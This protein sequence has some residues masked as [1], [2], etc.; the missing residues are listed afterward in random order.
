MINKKERVLWILYGIV[1]IVLFLLSSTDLIIKEKKASVYPIS[2]IIEDTSDDYYVN[3][4]KGMERAAV[5]LNADI[6]FITLYEQGNR[7]QQID[8]MLREQENEEIALIM[9]PVDEALAEELQSLKRINVPLVLLNVE[10]ELIKE[11]SVASVTHDYFLMGC[12]LG[13]RIMREQTASH[14]VYILGCEGHELVNKRILLGLSSVLEPAGYE[15]KD[16]PLQQTDDLKTVLK[17]MAGPSDQGA[18][19]AALDPESLS[20]AAQLAADDQECAFWI[21][22]LY[23]R[24]N[25]VPILNYLDKGIIQGLCVTDDFSAGYISIEI[26]VELMNGRLHKKQEYLESYCIGLEELQTGMYEK[27]LYPIE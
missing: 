19:L 15:L 9:A 27:I 10:E 11:D 4:K 12:Q 17:M 18:V 22:G 8:L 6:S 23:G 7:S 2:V 26:A 3:F 16:C 5:E 13:E 1:L 24:G 14:P 20:A 25:T 21:Q